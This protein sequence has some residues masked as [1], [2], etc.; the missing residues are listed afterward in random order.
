[1]DF[2]KR[3]LYRACIAFLRRFYGRGGGEGAMAI[4]KN[5]FSSTISASIDLKFCTRLEGDNKQN[6][7][8]ANF[9]FLPPPKKKIWHPFEFCVCITANG[10][11]NFKSALV[12]FPKLF[13]AD[14]FT[15]TSPRMWKLILTFSQNWSPSNSIFLHFCIFYAPFNISGTLEASELKFSHTMHRWWG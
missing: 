2:S 7:V 11:T 3:P 6:C 13:W 5:E 10:K 8:G 9:K 14:I 4:S 15:H 1:M 12:E